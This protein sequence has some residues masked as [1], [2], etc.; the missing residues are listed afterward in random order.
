MNKEFIDECIARAKNNTSECTEDILKIN[1]Y[2]GNMTRHLY[3][4]I[5]SYK[6]ESGRKTRSLEISCW[7]GSSTVSAL[8]KNDMVSTVIDN[9]SE[10]GGPK[11]EF[12]STLHQYF[13]E[14]LENIQVI[15]EDSFN[16]TTTLSYAPY[17]IYMYDGDHKEECHEKAIMEYWKYLSDTCI[18]LVDDWDW[19]CVKNGTR[20]GFEKI[21]ANI[22]YEVEIQGSGNEGFWN[23]CGVFL[24]KK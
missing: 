11:D 2:S 16:L 7:R 24:I 23:G 5:C 15:N 8:Y 10:F 21:N 19:E 17:D 14:Q 9:W 1:G 22:V 12:M 20:K 4:N 18:I 3:N 13:P 6:H